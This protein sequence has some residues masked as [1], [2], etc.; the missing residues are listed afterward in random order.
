MIGTI[1]PTTNGVKTADVKSLVEGWKTGT[2]PNYGLVL[3][4][5]GTATADASYPAARWHSCQPGPSSM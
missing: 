5:T 2:F 1:A 4:S 3:L